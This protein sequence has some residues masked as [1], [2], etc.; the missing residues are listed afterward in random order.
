MILV[1]SAFEKE[2]SR[3]I[4]SVS[5]KKEIVSSGR[6]FLCGLWEGH[7]IMIGCTGVGRNAARQVCHALLEEYRPD[8]FIYIGT[9]GSLNPGFEPGDMVAAGRIVC[10]G[11]TLPEL[12]S[13][14]R[15]K[16]AA[17]SYGGEE[18][19]IE[20][21]VLTCDTPVENGEL[22]RELVSVYGGDCVDMEGYGAAESAHIYGVPFLLV[23]IISDRA[24]A[25]VRTDFRKFIKKASLYSSNILRHIL[26]K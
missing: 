2:I 15:L 9:A 4:A 3:I 18:K 12:G 22:K 21:T 26:N 23:R 11:E 7:E 19:I 10:C 6:T 17:L 1:L 25:G 20:G 24:D 14:S 8:F 16:E 5:R 13:D